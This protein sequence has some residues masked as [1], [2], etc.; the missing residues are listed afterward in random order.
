MLEKN[1]RRN[2]ASIRPRHALCVIKLFILEG[3]VG[4]VEGDLRGRRCGG[5]TTCITDV[6]QQSKS[7]SL[8]AIIVC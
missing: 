5:H 8:C 4:A 3:F 1:Q 6:M 7:V 2:K